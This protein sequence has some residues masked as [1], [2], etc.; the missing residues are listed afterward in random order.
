[1]SGSYMWIVVQSL[2]YVQLCDPMNCSMPGF[3]VSHYLQSLLK[4]MSIE[5]VIPSNHLILCHPLL[6]LPSIF[7]SRSFPVSQLFAFPCAKWCISCKDVCFGVVL[8]TSRR[9]GRECYDRLFHQ[10]ITFHFSWFSAGQPEDLWGQHFIHSPLTSHEE[11]KQLQEAAGF[12]WAPGL[13]VLSSLDGCFR[14]AHCWLSSCSVSV[15]LSYSVGAKM[16]YSTNFCWAFT[17]CQA[18]DALDY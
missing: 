1:M 10:S 17:L 16:H 7:P 12:R 15:F 8:K 11:R 2:S 18:H 13:V 6:L 4:L 9:M 14:G 5:S 3:P